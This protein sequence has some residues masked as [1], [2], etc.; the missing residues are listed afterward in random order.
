M[1]SENNQSPYPMRLRI[2]LTLVLLAAVLL[3][4][5][6]TESSPTT[7]TTT[8]GIVTPPNTATGLTADPCSFEYLIENAEGHFFQRDSCYFRTHTPMDFLNDL[9]RHPHQPVMV[10]DVPDDWI[11]LQDA[12]MLMQEIDAQEPAASVVSPLSSYWPFNQSSTVGNE[13]LFLLEGY[14][15]GR[16]PPALCSLYYFKPNRTE[17]QLWWNS[18][19]ERGAR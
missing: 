4:A 12:A 11:T 14:R 15:T 13:A 19:G 9:S 17:V 8:P 18:D 3:G 2:L 7:G 6:C 5:G 10:L 16:Y 1:M